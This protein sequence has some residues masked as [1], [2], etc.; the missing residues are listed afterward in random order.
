MEYLTGGEPTTAIPITKSGSP[1]F[2]KTKNAY[3]LEDFKIIVKLGKGA[4]GNV[5]LIELNKSLNA[6]PNQVK[7]M[8]YAMKVMDKGMIME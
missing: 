6:A 4:F 3:L 1:R 7:P 8:R 5:Y 2:V